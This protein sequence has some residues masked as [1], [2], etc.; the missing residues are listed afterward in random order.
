MKVAS[1]KEFAELAGITAIVASLIFVGLQVR[2]DHRIAVA[3]VLSQY[4][5]NLIEM[6]R[7]VSENREIWVNG[8]NGEELSKLDE[9]TFEAIADAVDRLHSNRWARSLIIDTLPSERVAQRYA[10]NIYAHPGLRTYFNKKTA[11]R[12]SLRSAFGGSQNFQFY[13]TVQ[14]YL[15]KLDSELPAGADSNTYTLW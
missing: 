2:Q 7:L 5:A 14:N 3:H 8:L 6:S 15:T 13:S 11:R 12:R 9:V 4:D 10:F 1:W